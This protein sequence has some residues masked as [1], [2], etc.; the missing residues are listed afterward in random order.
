LP[1]DLN[2]RHPFAFAGRG[3]CSRRLE[4]VTVQEKRIRHSGL[5]G[6]ESYNPQHLRCQGRGFRSLKATRTTYEFLDRQRIATVRAFV[7]RNEVKAPVLP[8]KRILEHAPARSIRELIATPRPSSDDPQPKA[9]AIVSTRFDTSGLMRNRRARS[10]DWRSRAATIRCIG[11]VGADE[12]EPSRA[13]E[14]VSN[15]PRRI[16]S[17]GAVSPSAQHRETH[18][19]G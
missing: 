15:A 19:A 6:G 1:W 10:A 11:A 18:R 13:T 16:L 3:E 12:A 14:C 2:E 8:G 9:M 4:R 7:G 5:D 17:A